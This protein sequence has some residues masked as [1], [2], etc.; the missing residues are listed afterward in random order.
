MRFHVCCLHSL[1]RFGPFNTDLPVLKYPSVPTSTPTYDRRADDIF[2]DDSPLLH[3][4]QAPQTTPIASLLHHTPTRPTHPL[5]PIGPTD[6]NLNKRGNPIP[7]AVPHT[8]PDY[9][10]HHT[11]PLPV[12]ILPP[13]G[14]NLKKRGHPLSHAAPHARP[15]YGYSTLP[16][17]THVLLPT[18]DLVGM[19]NNDKH[20]EGPVTETPFVHPQ[21][22]T[23]TTTPK[24][25]SSCTEES[26][27]VS[28]TEAALLSH[29]AHSVKHN[30][31]TGTAIVTKE[32]GEKTTLTY[33][34]EPEPTYSQSKWSFSN[35]SPTQTFSWAQETTIIADYSSF[36]AHITTKTFFSHLIISTPSAAIQHTLITRPHP[37]HVED[38]DKLFAAW[39][40]PTMAPSVVSHGA[41]AVGAPTPTH[42]KC[43]TKLTTN[44][45]FTHGPTSTK[46]AA[47]ATHTSYVPCGGCD[48]ELFLPFGIG[49]Q[50]HYT[51]TVTV[52]ETKTVDIVECSPTY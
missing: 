32:N 24:S 36:Q 40:A 43:T 14:D 16:R 17:P 7:H 4:S 42:T 47:T 30:H 48:L 26:K 37:K 45:W 38:E 6:D 23:P 46:F 2:P 19:L 39:P 29:F 44:N 10:G 22:S 11:L 15:N 35:P 50:I 12:N 25:T 21:F 3:H 13:P 31:S 33:H 41:T 34:H 9:G 8:R 18:A 28:T 5:R 27:S 51:T 20:S 52:K 1:K 49:P